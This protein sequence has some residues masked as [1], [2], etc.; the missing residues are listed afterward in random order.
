V[1]HED[2]AV[3]DSF[4]VGCITYYFCLKSF[5]CRLAGAA[6]SKLY[7]SDLPSS[8]TITQKEFKYFPLGKIRSVQ[9]L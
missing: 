6:L 4:E 3:M 2:I 5:L 1:Q 8:S 9:K 7:G